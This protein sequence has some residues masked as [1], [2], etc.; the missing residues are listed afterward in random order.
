MLRLTTMGAALGA[1]LMFG[2]CASI[3]SGQN[4]SV[5][6]TTQKNGTDVA[7]AK[8]TLSNDKGT[9][10]TTSPGS[11]MVRRSYNDMMVNCALDGSDPGI[12]SVKSSTKGMAFGNILFGGIIGVGVDMSTGAAYDYPTLIAV[13]L[14]QV[15]TFAPPVAKP[16]APKESDPASITSRQDPFATAKK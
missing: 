2:G 16:D 10:Y 6:V 9:W 3:V 5:S 11:V 1:C 4:Q 7:G 14:G 13:N 8:C 15:G 12:L